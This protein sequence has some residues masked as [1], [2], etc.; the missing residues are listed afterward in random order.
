MVQ[1]TRPAQP[2]QDST[3]EAG[4]W[5]PRVLVWTGRVLVWTGRVR[6]TCALQKLQEISLAVFLAVPTTG[7]LPGA[8]PGE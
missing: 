4:E 3:E 2:A 5:C 7:K 8:S 1:N 6:G